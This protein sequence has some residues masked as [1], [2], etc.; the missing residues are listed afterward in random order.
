MA[1]A[2]KE[3]NLNFCLI[4]IK[5]NLNSHIWLVAIKLDSEALEKMQLLIWKNPTLTSCCFLSVY[6]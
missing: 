5:Q 6:C 1:S 2:A 4:L 3:L